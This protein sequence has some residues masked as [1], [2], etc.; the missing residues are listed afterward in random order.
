MP[1]PRIYTLLVATLALLTAA[2]SED[3]TGPDGTLAEQLGMTIHLDT[4]EPV[5]ID[6]QDNVTTWTFDPEDGPMCLRGDPFRA[7]IRETGHDDLVIFLQGGG[8]CW[9]AFCLAVTKAPAGVP[10]INL[11]NPRLDGNPFAEWNVLYLPYCDGS[12]FVGDIDHDDAG[13]G[14]PDRFHRGLHNLSAAL[15]HGA[16]TLPE[17]RRI[18]L[19]GSSAGGYGTLLATLLVR[20]VWP[21]SQLFVMNDSGTGIALDGDPDFVGTLLDEFNARRF[22]PDDCTGCLENGHITPLIGWILDRDAS[23]RFALFSSLHDS[24]ITDVFLGEDPDTFAHALLRETDA[25]RRDHPDRFARFLIE[26]RMHTTLLGDVSGI[27]GSDLTAVELPDGILGSLASLEIGRM[28]RTEDHEGLP[29]IDWLR[30]MVDDS[31]GWND[32]V[33]P[34]GL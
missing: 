34:A 6:R 27:V 22:V 19:A 21:N 14:T 17:P 10:R 23:L 28:L 1:A 8:A 29:F 11:L 33:P 9:S 12:L 3:D 25:I 32:R 31:E 5:D 24:I 2:C 15:T 18:L 26:G 7:S 20:H 30:A 13:D 4:A 16:R